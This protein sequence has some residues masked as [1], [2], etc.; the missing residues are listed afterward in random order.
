MSMFAPFT[1]DAYISLFC[2]T[3]LVIHYYL[4][5]FSFFPQDTRSARRARYMQE[6]DN[7]AVIFCIFINYIAFRLNIP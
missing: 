1:A 6:Y 5:C 2:R 3:V 4:K 7:F